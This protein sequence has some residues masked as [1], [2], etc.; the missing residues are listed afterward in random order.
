MEQNEWPSAIEFLR[1]KERARRIERGENER[2]A[3]VNKTFHGID[4]GTSCCEAQ[5]G[6]V[7]H[8][9][10]ACI[11]NVLEGISKDLLWTASLV[12]VNLD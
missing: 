2:G 1:R 8:V 11:L 5:S 3:L 6:N 7:E 12:S 4:S 9:G 10:M